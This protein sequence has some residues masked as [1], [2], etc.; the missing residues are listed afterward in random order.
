[1]LTS[2]SK[3]HH[4]N[5]MLITMLKFTYPNKNLFSMNAVRASTSEIPASQ[6]LFTL[7]LWSPL[8]QISFFLIFG[9]RK[10][11]LSSADS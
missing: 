2:K 7:G 1:M 10:G 5:T 8:C 3:I 6:E 9:A 4:I 11:P